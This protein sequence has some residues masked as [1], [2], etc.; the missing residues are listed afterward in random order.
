MKSIFINRYVRFVLIALFFLG[1]AHGSAT[2]V[3]ARFTAPSPMAQATSNAAEPAP[4]R[5]IYLPLLVN[6][7]QSATVAPTRSTPQLIEAAFTNGEISA[8]ERALYLAYALYEPASLPAQFHSNVGWYGTQYVLELQNFMQSI[9]AAATDAVQQELS[10]LNTLAAT[11]CDNEDGA[12]SFN[13][14][15]FH[16]N[17]SAI[18]GGLVIADYVTSMEATFAIEVTQ[19]GWAKPPLCTGGETCSG[20]DNPFD[21][22]PI[23]I[24]NLGSGLYGYVTTGGEYSGFIGDNP[25]TPATET[26][27]LASCMVLNN[28]FSQF[29]EGTAAALDATTS[30]E[31]VHAIQYGYGDA[32]PN[33]DDMWYESSAAY[34]EDE[35]F[36]D[37]NSNYLYLW[38]V[39]TNALGEWPN[40][41]APFGI[42]QYSNLLF[43]RHVAEHNGG[44]N[45]AGGGEDVMQHFWENVAAGQDALVAYNNALVVEGTNLADAF[46]KYAIAAKFSKACTGGYVGDYC[47]EEGADYLASVGSLPPVQGTI[48]ANPGSYNG[49]VHNHYATNWVS[50]PTSGSPYQVTLSNTAAGGQLR[51]SLVCDTGSALTITPFSTVVG[52]GNATSI[53]SFSATGCASVVAVITNQEQTAGNPNSTTAHNYTLTISTAASTTPTA[54]ATNTPTNTPVAPTATA[55][56]TPTNTP[57]APTATATNTPTNTP[58]APTATATNTPT[59]TPIGSTATAT[60]TPTNTPLAPT[61]TAT[62]TP[63]APTATATNTPTNT[64]LAPTATATNTPTNT[65]LAPTATATNTPTNT[66]LAPTATATNTPTNTPVVSTATATNTPTNIPDAPTA[67]ATATLIPTATSE[68][69]Y[70]SSSFNGKVDGLDYRD[71]DILRYNKT[72]NQWSIFFDGSDV[73]VGNA[74]LDDFALLADSSILMTFDKA[75]SFPTLGTIDDADIVKFTPTQLGATTSGSFSLFFDGSAVGLAADSEDIDALAYTSDGKLLISTYGTAAVGTL[76]AKDEDLLR[77]TPTSLGATTAGS[78]EL[79]FDGSAVG[80]TAGN[81]DVGAALLKGANTLYLATRGNFAA[82]SLNA[83]QGDS[84]DI[85]G[86]TLGSTGL[87]STSCTFFAFFNG[88]LARFNRPIDGLSLGTATQ[89]ASGQAASEDGDEP[90]QFEVFPDATVVDDEEFDSFDLDQTDETIQGDVQIFLP[91]IER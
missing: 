91:L 3:A 90:A 40:N 6:G 51:G 49:S 79:Y 64:P 27:A 48:A 44:T 86:C 74:D 77:F 5:Q 35:I 84:D 42:S 22:Y 87:N 13:S 25:N 71:E 46:H 16:F 43:F 4:A 14:T 75:M 63:I 41:G 85:F 68:Q 58:L 54:T 34:M 7:A 53:A 20:V 60:N 1:G 70:F 23:Q 26:A 10:R 50:L 15:N 30:H 33:E 55:T 73:G 36:D 17:H 88:D 28:D 19:F 21:R 78:W 61:A 89:F 39:A 72:T 76:R 56:N 38:P 12:T 83:I 9:S 18:A 59:N 32:G 65:P 8:D 69:L 62:N 11:V 82:A 37:A 31:F 66:P 52:A 2:K 45:V 57:L 80:L 47:F 24:V 67:T 81:E 29:S